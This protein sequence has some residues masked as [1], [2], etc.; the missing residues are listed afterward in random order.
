[1]DF[2]QTEL[3]RV[4]VAQIAL[5][6]L[7]FMILGI[8]IGLWLGEQMCLNTLETIRVSLSDSGISAL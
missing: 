3:D 7:A 1:M 8:I 4:E 6:M 2:K 5:C